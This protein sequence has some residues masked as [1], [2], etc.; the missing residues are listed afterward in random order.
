M[1]IGYPRVTAV[2][3]HTASSLSIKQTVLNSN[4]GQN[5]KLTNLLIYNLSTLQ[6]QG[7]S[8]QKYNNDLNLATQNTQ[9]IR[10]CLKNRTR[11]RTFPK[12]ERQFICRRVSCSVANRKSIEITSLSWPSKSKGE[13]MISPWPVGHGWKV[14]QEGEHT[15]LI[16]HTKLALSCS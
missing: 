1:L 13:R 11:W 9:R 16:N 8:A 15:Q 2:K 12:R 10:D 14:W 7:L 5:R 4:T 3:L 6:I